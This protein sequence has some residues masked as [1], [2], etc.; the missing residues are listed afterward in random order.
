MNF[1]SLCQRVFIEGWAGTIVGHNDSANFDVLM[2]PGTV[3]TLIHTPPSGGASGAGALADAYQS[4]A[5]AI[6]QFNWIS[7]TT[8]NS[9][10]SWVIA[11]IDGSSSYRPVTVND[12]RTLPIKFGGF[13]T[14][15]AS[16]PDS[17][18]GLTTIDGVIMNTVANTISGAV[19]VSVGQP[20]TS[21]WPFAGVSIASN[22]SVTAEAWVGR[23]FAFAATTD[24][25]NKNIVIPVGF[26]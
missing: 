23:F 17:V 15:T 6:P 25:S 16:L 10:L 4:A 13:E 22:E 26:D 14:L 7:N 1:L 8:A 11:F 19:T 3:R 24:L 9:G 12:G 20:T 21:P 5:G 2:D 18:T